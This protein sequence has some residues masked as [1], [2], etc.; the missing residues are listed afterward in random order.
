MGIKN[1]AM[2]RNRKKNKYFP[3]TI[4][5]TPRII[6]QLHVTE[7]GSKYKRLDNEKLIIDESGSSD[8]Y[9]FMGLG[10]CI[11]AISLIIHNEIK[12]VESS[13]M[14]NIVFFLIGILFLIYNY[15]RPRK[16]IILDRMK[17]MITFPNY[18]W[19]RPF[20]IS[21]D[22]IKVTFSSKNFGVVPGPPLLTIMHPN[23]ITSTDTGTGFVFEEW[24][25]MVW[26]MDK[27]RPLPPGT[28]FDPYRDQDFERRKAEGF[29]EPLY[30]STI[31]IPRHRLKKKEAH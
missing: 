15:T 2:A 23:G 19:G 27:N 12:E 22:D 26:Y 1:I 7:K 25:L 20:T 6:E 9:I 3:R 4:E 29:P 30:P 14:G 16:L 11:G 31:S 18:L 5:G 28:A 13:L 10:F 21:F 8:I 24:W 17:G